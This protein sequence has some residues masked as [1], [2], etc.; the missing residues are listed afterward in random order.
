MTSGRRQPEA[1]CFG[2]VHSH[3][4]LTPLSSDKDFPALLVLH[5]LQ[6]RHDHVKLGP[7]S[8]VFIHADLHEFTNVG[9]MPGGMVG[10]RPSNATCK[11]KEK[12][13][14]SQ[15]L[16]LMSGETSS[17]RTG[18][19]VFESM[20][21]SP[22]PLQLLSLPPQ[23]YPVK[24]SHLHSNFHVGEVSKGYLPCHQPSQKHLQNSTYLAERLFVSSGFFCRARGIGLICSSCL[25]CLCSLP[26]LLSAPSL[27]SHHNAI[28][29]LQ[30]HPG[31][32]IH[33]PGAW[34]GELD[35]GHTDSSSHVLINLRKRR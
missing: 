2:E 21:R 32:C 16:S 24:C 11:H 14:E 26:L 23:V 1:Y 17:L 30:S 10:R 15:N 25:S 5:L 22:A 31:R 28:T 8:R 3:R 20:G 4:V 18:F 29:H 9:E 33:A 35:V 13:G 6:D 12:Q 7:L 34:E 27:P 19:C